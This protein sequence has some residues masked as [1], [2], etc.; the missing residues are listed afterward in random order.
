MTYGA[1]PTSLLAGLGIIRGFGEYTGNGTSLVINVGFSPT[2]IHCVNVGGAPA[3][4]R[5]GFKTAS[6]PSNNAVD[7]SGNS[8]V[9]ITITATGFT[10]DSSAMFNFN[11]DTYDYYAWR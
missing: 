9:G 4:R 8:A 3:S 1:P 5:G 7:H 6:M 2:Y 10:L 11:G